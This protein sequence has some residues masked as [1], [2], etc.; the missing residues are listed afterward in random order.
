[1]K[2]TTRKLVLM[3]IFIALGIVL[4]LFFHLFG[5]NLS[6]IISPMHLPVFIAGAFLGPLAGLLVGLITPLLSSLFTGM[7]PL[8]PMLPIMLIELAIYGFL[9]GYLFQSKKLNIYFSLVISILTGR[10]GAGL[11][12]WFLVHILQITHLP[13]NPLLYITATIV[14]G[15]PGIIIQLI[16][17]PLFIKYLQNIEQN[18]QQN[19]EF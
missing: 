17:V 10:I 13:A 2:I 19:F 7:P 16:L 3:A 1:M 14:K 15:L 8:L 9:C 6:S 5:A 12:V 18:N 11:V 4:P